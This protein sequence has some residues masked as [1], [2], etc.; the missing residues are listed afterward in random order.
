MF[1]LS[2]VLKDSDHGCLSSSSK[3]HCTRF[4]FLSSFS[5]SKLPPSDWKPKEYTTAKGV[6]GCITEILP[7]LVLAFVHPLLLFRLFPCV[8][9]CW[10]IRECRSGL[11]VYQEERC[12][13][14]RSAS[15]SLVPLTSDSN[16]RIISFGYIKQT[17]IVTVF[18]V[19]RYNTTFPLF[20]CL[21]ICCSF[22]PSSSHV[23]LITR[24]QNKGYLAFCTNAFI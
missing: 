18:S 4:P 17:A 8:Y 24:L 7:S 11:W 12:L 1:Q 6:V 3:L 20:N 23:P 5:L 16:W 9:Q 22:K 21:H 15:M 13:S 14:T 2:A 10:R 19:C